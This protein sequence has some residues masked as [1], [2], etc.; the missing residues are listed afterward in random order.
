MHQSLL[1][2]AGDFSKTSASGPAFQFRDVNATS[3]LHYTGNMP[4]TI[5]VGTNLHVTAQVDE[6]E[7]N[8]C[9]FL[10]ESVETAFRSTR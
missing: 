10:L 6:Y 5:G 4:D 7:P 1:I 2:G 3:D 8:S 9:P